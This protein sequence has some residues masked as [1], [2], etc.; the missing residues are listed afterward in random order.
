MEISIATSE[1]TEQ[2]ALFGSETFWQAYRSESK[3]EAKYIR[4]YMAKAFSV[5]Q[6]KSEIE[7][8]HIEFL[9]AT[10]D[11]KLIGYSKLSFANNHESLQ[12]KKPM[13]LCRIYLAKSYWG[14]GLGKDLLD[15][16]VDR[17]I[18]RSCD[19]VWLGVWKQN[20]RAIGF[21]KK[22]GFEIVG[23]VEFDLA[24][25]IQSDHVMELVVGNPSK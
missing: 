22:H 25:S 18:A 24:S 11:S 7:D 3:L 17:A 1:Q 10:Q 21:Y 19:S 9:L 6:I 12:G 2:L 15:G 5:Q 16:C 8:E 4:A 13:E 23:E 14:K 20:D